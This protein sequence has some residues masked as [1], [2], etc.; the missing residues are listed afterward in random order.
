MT[1][2]EG[3][4]FFTT[5]GGDKPVWKQEGKAGTGRRNTFMATLRHQ[6]GGSATWIRK[7]PRVQAFAR[8]IRGT[9]RDQ[10]AIQSHKVLPGSAEGD[11]AGGRLCL[12]TGGASF[13]GKMFNR[14]MAR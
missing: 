13:D 5:A 9:F 6:W 14:T 3:K 8:A 4:V 2:Q 7:A 12:T 11:L 10:R 1:W